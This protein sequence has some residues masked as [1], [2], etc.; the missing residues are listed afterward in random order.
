MAY[1]G[2]SVPLRRMKKFM[3]KSRVPK[4]EAIIIYHLGRANGPI[5]FVSATNLISGTKAK[6]S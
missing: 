4:I 2:M 1:Q 5:I 3:K 6:G